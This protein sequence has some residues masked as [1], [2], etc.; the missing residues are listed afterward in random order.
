MSVYMHVTVILTVT[1]IYMNVYFCYIM[2]SITVPLQGF[3]NAMIYGWTREDFVQAVRTSQ[4]GNAG[5][6][7]TSSKTPAYQ[8]R[9]HRDPSFADRPRAEGKHAEAVAR[10]NDDS[11]GIMN[12]L[13]EDSDSDDI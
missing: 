7:V 2:Q 8:Q 1:R 3:V 5:I 4:N 6:A 12:T 10:R 11:A 13:S 9:R